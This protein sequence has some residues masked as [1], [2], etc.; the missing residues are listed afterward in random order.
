MVEL[1]L[2]GIDRTWLCMITLVC[3]PFIL[4]NSLHFKLNVLEA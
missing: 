4:T 2:D 3:V 1:L